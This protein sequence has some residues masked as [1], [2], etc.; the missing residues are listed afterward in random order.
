MERG[1]HSYQNQIVQVSKKIFTSFNAADESLICAFIT[2]LF[3]R[4]SPNI[5][6]TEYSGICEVQT[7]EM[8]RIVRPNK[9]AVQTISLNQLPGRNL[10]GVIKLTEYRDAIQSKVLENEIPDLK[11]I[12][13]ELN[14]LGDRRVK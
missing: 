8:C 3:L 7:N 2:W 13:S 12:T 6:C 14:M 10:R 9:M 11:K 1:K 5:L 4:I